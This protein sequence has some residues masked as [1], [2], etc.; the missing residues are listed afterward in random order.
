MVSHRAELLTPSLY[1]LLIR[2]PAQSALVRR[3]FLQVWDLI[4]SQS[5]VRELCEK[6]VTGTGGSDCNSL[7]IW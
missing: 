2:M 6:F 3:N 5:R 1:T 7:A 4:K